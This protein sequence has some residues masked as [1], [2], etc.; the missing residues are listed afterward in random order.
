MATFTESE[1]DVQSID[2]SL[3][4]DQIKIA[5]VVFK[6]RRRFEEAEQIAKKYKYEYDT[7]NDKYKI[8]SK[9]LSIKEPVTTITEQSTK[10]FSKD[11]VKKTKDVKE[12]NKSFVG[13]S[14]YKTIEIIMEEF[15]LVKG[16]YDKQLEEM[17]ELGI[18]NN[19]TN[20]IT[21]L[22]KYRDSKIVLP[23]IIEK[24]SGPRPM[25]KICN[26]KVI[27]PYYR[28]GISKRCSH[29]QCLEWLVQKINPQ[30]V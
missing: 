25:C 13:S 23:D 8:I 29:T 26:M 30:M 19:S 6:M 5:N 11:S 9:C 17:E 24:N 28:I 14:G 1:Y 7:W 22:N 15:L 3:K 21:L 4:Q 16:N 20:F 12:P 2:E 10:E 18:Y 27:G